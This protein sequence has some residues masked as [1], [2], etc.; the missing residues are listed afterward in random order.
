MP[1]LDPEDGQPVW[2]FAEGELVLPSHRAIERLGTG[3]R[4]ETWLAWSES[5]WSP[6]VVKLVRP[7]QIDH[8]RGRA[9]IEREA[10]ALAAVDHPA[11][12]RL[13]IDG[14]DAAIP[15]LVMHYVDG[16]DL[17]DVLD[18]GPLDDVDLIYLAAQLGSAL[19]SLHGAGFAHLDL[20]PANIVVKAANVV[21]LDL[22]SARALGRSQPSGRP[23]GTVGYAAPE[24]EEGA[25]ISSAMDVFGLGV[26]LAEAALG[27]RVF[28][29]TDGV[30]ERAVPTLPEDLPGDLRALVASMLAPESAQR[31]SLDDVLARL[32]DLTMPADGG[33][34]LWPSWVTGLLASGGAAKVDAG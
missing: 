34:A 7:E 22:G 4:C 3:T 31:P 20:K 1:Q 2:D 30:R 21:L 18:D 6:V 16:P 28:D 12:P 24:L 27:D 5:L 11:T 13:L 29:P 10:S 33:G 9:A 32:G 8:P 15:H 19:R 17:D 25:D 23:I 14:R 26:V